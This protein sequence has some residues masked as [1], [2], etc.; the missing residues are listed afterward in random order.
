MTDEP[1]AFAILFVGLPVFVLAA[2]LGRRLVRP[3]IR[4]YQDE[5]ERKDTGEPQPEDD[6]PTEMHP[7]DG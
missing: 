6:A 7:H 4:R 5:L 3:C 1:Q 2:L